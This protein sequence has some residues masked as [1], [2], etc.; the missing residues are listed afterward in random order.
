MEPEICPV[1]MCWDGLAHPCVCTYVCPYLYHFSC[2]TQQ[3]GSGISMDWML[4]A[5][6]FEFSGAL[7]ETALKQH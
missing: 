5:T 6:C 3:R 7:G 4:A 1:V 2:V